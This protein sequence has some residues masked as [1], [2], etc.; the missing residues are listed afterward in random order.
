MWE[1]VDGHDISD[2]AGGCYI[3]FVAAVVM[4]G[5]SYVESMLAMWCITG[6]L[7]GCFMGKDSGSWWRYGCTVEVEITVETCVGRQ[8]GVSAR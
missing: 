8:I 2:S 4:H 6:S 7:Q 1:P 5:G 3:Y